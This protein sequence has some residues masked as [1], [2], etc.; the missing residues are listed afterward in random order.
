MLP[1]RVSNPGT[2]TYESD[3]L[4]TALRG[5]AVFL[6]LPMYFITGT[7]YSEGK[8]KCREIFL[9]FL[10]QIHVQKLF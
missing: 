9:S 4:Q 7:Y 1:D 6:V 5:P 8:I 3:S 10:H 2:L